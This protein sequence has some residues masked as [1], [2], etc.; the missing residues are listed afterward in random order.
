MDV[1]LSYLGDFATCRNST[2][3][4]SDEMDGQSCWVY[5]VQ[6]KGNVVSDEAWISKKTR[7]PLYFTK[8]LKNGTRVD[9]HIRLLK[10][11]FSI[12]DKTCFNTQNTA[13]M[14]TPFLKP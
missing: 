11:D 2:P 5:S 3:V 1:R 6:P 8:I 9:S 12:L 7:F 4:R 13:P 10:S 14:L